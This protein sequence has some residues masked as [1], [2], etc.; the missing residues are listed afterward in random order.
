MHEVHKILPISASTSY[1]C[2]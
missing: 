1:T 2:W